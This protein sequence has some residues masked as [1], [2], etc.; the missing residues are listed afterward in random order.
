LRLIPQP[1]KSTGLPRLNAGFIHP[2]QPVF[3]LFPNRKKAIIWLSGMIIDIYLCSKI[4]LELT[5][6]TFFR[7]N[8]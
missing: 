4:T 8:C 1:L 6:A 5:D 2:Y 3:E 7:G